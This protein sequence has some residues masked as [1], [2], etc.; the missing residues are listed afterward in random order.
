VD[1]EVKTMRKDMDDE[2]K[3]LKQS[4]NTTK[5]DDEQDAEKVRQVEMGKR[6]GIC[7]ANGFAGSLRGRVCRTPALPV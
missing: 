6:G 3:D 5:E 4:T 7:N 2:F 1:V